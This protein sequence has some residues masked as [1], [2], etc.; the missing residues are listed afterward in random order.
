MISCIKLAVWLPKALI[1]HKIKLSNLRK[2]IFGLGSRN[3]KQSKNDADKNEVKNAD[4]EKGNANSTTEHEAEI[5]ELIQPSNQATTQGHGWLPHSAYANTIDHK[6]LIVDLKSGD[7][8]PMLCGGKVYYFEPG[9]MVR[10]KG[11]NLAAVHKYWID[12]LRCGSCSHL[13]TAEIPRHIGDSKYD[14][15]FKAILALQNIT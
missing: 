7:P 2:L 1:E 3:K 6:V 12:K 4:E 9:V 15:A 13:V 14:A 10:V 8:C 5:A 11:Q